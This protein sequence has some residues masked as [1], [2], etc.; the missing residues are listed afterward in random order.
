MQSGSNNRM[1]YGQK[2]ENGKFSS[3]SRYLDVIAHELT[4]GVTQYTSN[5]VYQGQSGALNESFSDIFGVIITQRSLVQIQPPQ[6][7]NQQ[8][9]VL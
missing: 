3:Y 8:L 9:T 1:W 4:H 7:K 2:L 5:L 6:P